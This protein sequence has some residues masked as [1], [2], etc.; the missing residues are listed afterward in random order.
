MDLL[1]KVGLDVQNT[2]NLMPEAISIPWQLAHVPKK[3]HDQTIY[4]DEGYLSIAKLDRITGNDIDELI[5]ILHRHGG[6][7]DL[8]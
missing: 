7:A 1:K 6:Y 2:S 5:R 3:L 4:Q 8:I